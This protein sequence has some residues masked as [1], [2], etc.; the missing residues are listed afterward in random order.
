MRLNLFNFESPRSSNGDNSF[1][2][3]F[4]RAQLETTS[5]SSS[6]LLLAAT[7]K[8]TIESMTYRE[9]CM[10]V[11]RKAIKDLDEDAW[12]FDSTNPTF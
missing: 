1:D 3:T 9:R 2:R 6:S 7:E 4:Q 8:L 12:Q 5:L 10:E 11:L